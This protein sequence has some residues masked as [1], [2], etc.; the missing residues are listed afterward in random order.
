MIYSWFFPYG[1]DILT[2]PLCILSVKSGAHSHPQCAMSVN[3][4]HLFIELPCGMPTLYLCVTL[5][6]FIVSLMEEST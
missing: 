6:D 1:R 4:E 2:Y 3:G 5:Q